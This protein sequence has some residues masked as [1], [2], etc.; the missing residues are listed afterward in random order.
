MAILISFF[1]SVSAKKKVAFRFL[2]FNSIPRIPTPILRIPILMCRIP[3]QIPRIPTL[4]YT[5]SAF[6][7]FPALFPSFPPP[8]PFPDFPFRL[9]QIAST[10]YICDSNGTQYE[11]LNL[12]SIQFSQTKLMLSYS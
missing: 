1:F 3:T 9:L 5:F 12:K 10:H 8:I 7:V 4:F 11:I 2:Y 6:L